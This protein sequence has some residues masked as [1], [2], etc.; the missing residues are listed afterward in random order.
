MR[1]MELSWD[2]LHVMY[3]AK[4]VLNVFRQAH[5]YKDG[6]YIKFW[7]GKED[8]VVLT[9]LLTARPDATVE[10]LTVKLETIYQSLTTGVA[11]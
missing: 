2:Q 9:D 4:N 6:T 7:Y 1:R 10:Q 5:G 8:N 11:A 3:V